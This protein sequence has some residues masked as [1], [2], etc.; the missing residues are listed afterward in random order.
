MPVLKNWNLSIGVDQ[1]LRAI[2]ADPQVLR[3]RR[4]A[5]V[6]TAEWSLREGL[7]LLEPKVLYLQAAVKGF[8]HER[9]EL[10][11][12]KGAGRNLFL[13]GP[14]I[15]QHL[16]PAEQV[17]VIVC[18]IGVS[19]EN[20]ASEL[21]RTDPLWGWMMDGLGSA[22]VETLALEACNYFEDQAARNGM[23]TSLPLSP[24]MIGWPV[25]QGQP[26]IFSLV[27]GQ[28]VGITLTS[29]DQMIPRKTLSMVLGVGANIGRGGRTCDYCSLSETC[30][31]QNHYIPVQ[32]QA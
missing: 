11:N 6:K 19:L 28:D 27:D 13:K 2:G 20:I 10:D 7:P 25:E 8:R 15:G 4:P 22:A 26:Q 23:H 24:G 32:S 18:T 3:S 12:P 9:L 30:Q 21:M 17:I 16:G 5:L 1:V 14:L 29:S 31:Y